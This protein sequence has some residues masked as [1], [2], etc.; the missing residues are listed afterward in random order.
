AVSVPELPTRAGKSTPRSATV[1]DL[2]STLRTTNGLLPR[3][4]RARTTRF[5]PPGPFAP[6]HTGAIKSFAVPKRRPSS[7]PSAGPL[8]VA[9]NSPTSP[10]VEPGSPRRLLTAIFGVGA[11]KISRPSDAGLQA[12]AATGRML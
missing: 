12:T 9:T 1:P 10:P 3:S 8:G 2:G 11:A 5:A 4:D 6:G 7:A